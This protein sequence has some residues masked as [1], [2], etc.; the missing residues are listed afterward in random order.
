MIP[1]PVYNLNRRTAVNCRNIGPHDDGDRGMRTSMV[2]TYQGSLHT[3]L[4]SRRG[5]GSYPLLQTRMPIFAV[6]NKFGFPMWLVR[7]LSQVT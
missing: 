7:T 6:A 1:F 3:S 5:S 4:E 2:R